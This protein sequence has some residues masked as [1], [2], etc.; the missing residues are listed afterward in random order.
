MERSQL[1]APR[2][3]ARSGGPFY[4]AWYVVASSP[5]EG[6][7]LWVRYTMDVSVTGA[8]EVDGRM[9]DLRGVPAGQAHV[10]GKKRYPSWAWGRCSAFAE[11][12][13]AS[14]DL[15]TVEGPGG[16]MVP[17]FTFRRRGQV[18]HFAKAPWI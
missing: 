18:H 9:I 13:S 8:V 4:E 14:L 15:L 1:N 16:V 6:L 2:W 11:D 10:W 7:G 12:P 3:S 5:R 17:L